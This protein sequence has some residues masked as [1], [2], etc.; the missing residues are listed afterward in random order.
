MSVYKYR[1]GYKAEAWIHGRRIKTKSGFRT[2]KLAQNWIDRIKVDLFNGDETLILKERTFDELL[3]KYCEV[4]LGT[5]KTGTARRYKI[6]LVGRIEPFFQ[7][8]K[9]NHITPNVV[10]E[11]R[12]KLIISNLSTKSVNNCTDLLSSIFRKAIDWGWLDKN[13]VKLKRMTP[14]RYGYKWWD[15]KD[16]IRTFVEGSKETPYFAAYMLALECGLRLGEIVG[17]S[18][19]DVSFEFGTI[20]IHRQWLDK[21]KCY[22]STKNG[23]ERYIRFSKGSLVEA[24]LRKAIK[25]SPDP[26]VI[27]VTSTGKRVGAR[28]LSAGRFQN[29]IKKLNL[30]VIKFHDLRHTFA[31]WYM[32]QQGDIWSLMGI[33]G[34]SSV[35]TTMRYAHVS[36]KHQR[37]PKFDWGEENPSHSPLKPIN[38]AELQV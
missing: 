11:F 15:S 35:K 22:G 17:L 34:H 25:E 38:I 31:S 16:V 5:V 14:D 13:P 18:K 37:V 24:A 4:H 6:D 32:I 36:S 7:Y 9:L 21:D 28:N 27:F 26:E 12:S 2:K 33:L 19:Q 1:G 10:E 8:Y 29:L 23:R 20:K 3:Q 30:P